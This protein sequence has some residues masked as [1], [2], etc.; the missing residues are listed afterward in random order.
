VQVKMLEKLV[1]AVTAVEHRKAAYGRGKAKGQPETWIDDV[2]QVKTPPL[3]SWSA[4]SLFWLIAQCLG[5]C[6]PSQPWE[7]STVGQGGYYVVY[8]VA[9]CCFPSEPY[10]Q[11]G[12]EMT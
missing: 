8:Y 9:G 4:S 12:S 2:A 11:C 7:A 5:Q 10:R 6:S 3:I 1:Q